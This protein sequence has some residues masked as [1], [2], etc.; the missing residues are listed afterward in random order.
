MSEE[1]PWEAYSDPITPPDPRGGNGLDWPDIGKGFAG[2]VGRGVSALGGIQGSV[3][4]LMNAGL[5]KIGVPEKYLAPHPGIFSPPNAADVQKVME[6]YTGPL[7]EPKTVPGQY[8]ST[9]GEFTP[10]ALTPGG[11]G[12]G[13][14]IASTVIPALTSETAGQFTKGTEAEPWA[15]F[16]GGMGGGLAST[17][18][19]TPAPPATPARVR[20]VGILEREGIPLTAGERTGSNAVKWL[21]ATAGDLPLSSGA[22]QARRQEALSALDRAVT[23][24]VFDPQELERRGLPPGSALPAADVMAHGRQSLSDEY[25]RLAAANQLRADPQL[26]RDLH[27]AEAGYHNLALP[28][29]R[30]TGARDVSAIRD[31]LVN[32]LLAGQGRMPGEAYQAARSRMGTLAESAKNTDPVL[33]N[34]LRDFRGALD[35][36][37]QRGLSPEDAAAWALNNRRYANMKQLETATAKGGENFSPAG[38]AQSVRAG[39]AGQAAVNAGDLDELTKAAA[40]VMKPMPSSGTAQRLG[41]Q[42]LFG[43]PGVLTAGGG[44]IGSVFGPLGTA[45]GAVAPHLVGRAVVSNLGQRYLGNQAVPR[46]RE[47]IVNQLLAQQYASQPDVIARNTVEQAA[48]EKKRQEER[49]RAGL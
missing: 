1:H 16:A 17:R 9:L 21:E 30:A 38:V 3:R 4:D 10:G 35:R 6:K 20:D 27:A 41:W 36:A 48:A 19:V 33:A 31:D 11:G 43:L 14:R 45:A 28:S 47:S 39:R 37:M 29:Q 13:A 22:A 40:A 34:T 2:G 15:R 49:N 8:A 23:R 26:V 12:V 24:R 18:L 7:Y 32:A 44:G 46:T 5:S 25:T 42:S